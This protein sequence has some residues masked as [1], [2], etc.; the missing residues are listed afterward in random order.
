MDPWTTLTERKRDRQRTFSDYDI[1]FV[2]ELVTAN[3]F[4][5]S[6]MMDLETFE[7]ADVIF[8]A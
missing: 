2:D 6:K 5:I 3:R 1:V 7:T 4:C 8:N